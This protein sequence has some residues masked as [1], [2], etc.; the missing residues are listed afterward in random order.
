HGSC[1]CIF[2]AS[3]NPTAPPSISPLSLHDALPIC[4]VQHH[5]GGLLVGDVLDVCQ[6]HVHGNSGG[7]LGDILLAALDHGCGVVH[8]HNGAALWQVMAQAQG[9][10]TQGAAQVIAAGI[11]TA[12]T[13]GDEAGHIRDHG[14]AGYGSVDHVTEHGR[15]FF[16]ENEGL[17]G[18]RRGRVNL[19]AVLTL[20]HFLPNCVA[21]GAL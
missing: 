17:D 9:G 10:S 1:A 2:S 3:L 16:I 6:L 8:R 20:A 4:E 11:G 13:A 14:V 7:V 21:G 19:V 12:I 5:D 15:Y 18:I